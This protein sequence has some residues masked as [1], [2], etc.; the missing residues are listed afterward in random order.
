MQKGMTVT[1]SVGATVHWSNGSNVIRSSITAWQNVRQG[2]K[3]SHN[4]CASVH[5]V[6][7]WVC[8]DEWLLGKCRLVSFVSSWSLFYP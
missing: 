6:R 2:C 8:V 3:P 5:C 7:P 1:A 4:P